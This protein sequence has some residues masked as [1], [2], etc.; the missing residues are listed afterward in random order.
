VNPYLWRGPVAGLRG[1]FEERRDEMAF[2]QRQ[3]P[4]YAVHGW[5]ERPWLTIS[6]SL[7]VGPLAESP[8]AAPAN[9][10]LLAV[11]VAGLVGLLR[12]GGPASPAG[13][14][15]GWTLGYLVVVVLGLGL[16]Y[17]RYF[18]PTTLV[19]LPLVAAGLTSAA[20]AIWRRRPR[21]ARERAPRAIS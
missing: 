5:L 19:F 9:L 2:Q 3:W 4:E 8:L 14:L 10:P 21:T 11:G 13:M 15:A 20:Q 1:M 17:P 18:M 12:R 16:K 6:G 7:Q